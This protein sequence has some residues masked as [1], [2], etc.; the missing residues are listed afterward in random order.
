MG[1]LYRST[2]QTVTLAHGVAQNIDLY[3]PFSHTEPGWNPSGRTQLHI[4]MAVDATAGASSDFAA[5]AAPIITPPEETAVIATVSAS[6]ASAYT[7]ALTLETALNWA[8]GATYVYELS[9]VMGVAQPYGF[10]INATYSGGAG[11]SMLAIFRLV[12]E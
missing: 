4:T 7:A 5:T 1:A 3:I 6:A 11:D 8:D 2:P 9:F 10:R 12:V